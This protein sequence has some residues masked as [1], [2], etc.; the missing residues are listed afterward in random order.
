MRIEFDVGD[1]R[2]EFRR[3]WWTEQAELRVGDQVVALEDALGANPH[4]SRLASIWRHHIGHHE[5][6][7]ESARPARWAR[8]RP[9]RY[10][11]IVDDELV[12]EERGM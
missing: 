8:W 4:A 11:V 1:V 7:V 2:V 6:V 10:R 3:S 9:H 12:V 5:V